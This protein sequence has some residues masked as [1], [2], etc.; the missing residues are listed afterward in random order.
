MRTLIYL[1]IMWGCFLF[2]PT[3]MWGHESDIA[4]VHTASVADVQSSL[5][6]QGTVVLNKPVKVNGKVLGNSAIVNQTVVWEGQTYTYNPSTGK[7]SPRA[8]DDAKH[9]LPALKVS[10]VEGGKVTF[11]YSDSDQKPVTFKKALKKRVAPAPAKEIILKGP[12]C[13]V[14]PP[15]PKD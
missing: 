11:E 14:G 12:N 10:K 5:T 13:T 6:V 2:S 7:I 8:K 9:R 3:Y 15:S 4:H 1:M